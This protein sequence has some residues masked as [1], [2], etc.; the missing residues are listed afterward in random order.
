MF[1]NSGSAPKQSHG[2]T[3]PSQ[4]DS[5]RMEVE[6]TLETRL[7]HWNYDTGQIYGQALSSDYTAPM[8]TYHYHSTPMQL[9]M[10]QHS[11]QIP[12]IQQVPEAPPPYS[13]GPM[14]TAPFSSLGHAYLA[15]PRFVRSG[16]PI[17]PKRTSHTCWVGNLPPDVTLE[18]LRDHFSNGAKD[19]IESVFLM[20]RNCAFVNYGTEEAC[21]AAVSRLN[22]RLLGGNPLLCR[23]KKEPSDEDETSQQQAQ[24]RQDSLAADQ[25]VKSLSDATG[26]LSID[27]AATP[28]EQG[29]VNAA[30]IIGDDTNGVPE[31]RYFILKALNL[32]DLQESYRTGTWTTQL[33]VQRK[34]RKAFETSAVVYLI[35][36]VN[37]SGTYFGY[38]KM[39]SSPGKGQQSTREIFDGNLFAGLQ[40]M[41]TTETDKAPAGKI[42]NDPARGT[43]FWEAVRDRDGDTEGPDA[44]R[45][46]RIQWISSSPLPFDRVRGL[47][48]AWNSNKEVKVARDGTELETTAGKRLLQI[49]QS[50]NIDSSRACRNFI[51][52]STFSGVC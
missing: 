41:Q 14:R 17:L 39:L 21:K 12:Q 31:V 38:A 36:S 4:E 29:A 20:L 27:S 48:N 2:G 11:Y 52:S 33:H 51:S 46:F 34:L 23:V 32:E 16:P 7:P 6:Q 44:L 5:W 50:V 35:F 49:L 42:T 28:S 1:D 22:G 3:S 9:P 37:K 24:G 10:L 13:P 26:N 30:W 18:A 19:D 40:V 43:R 8:P 47:K 25:E 45:P 15:T